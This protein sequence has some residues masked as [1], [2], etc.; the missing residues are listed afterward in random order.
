MVKDM[1][2]EKS[3][4]AITSYDLVKTFAVIIMVI[5]HIGYYFF[6][7]DLWWRAVGRLCVPV[8]MFLIGYANSRDVS[9]RLWIGA[10][11]LVGADVVVGRPVLPLNILFTIMC[12]RLVIDWFVNLM[13]KNSVNVW[14]FSIVLI[15]FI[16][17]SDFITEYGTQA[18]IIAIYGYFVR[19]KEEVGKNITSNYMMFSLLVFVCFQQ[20]VFNF[21]ALEFK[22]MFVGVLIVHLMLFCFSLR[23][24]PKLTKMLPRSLT[25]FFQF[26]GHYTLEIYV[27]HL[28]AFKL[29]AT[30]LG[31]E[32]FEWFI[33]SSGLVAKP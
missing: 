21:F 10:F 32:G 5:D 14:L 17:P 13:L 30:A 25:W 28:L 33:F 9:L 16:L 27:V 15:V 7:D 22:F 11:V 29:L 8:W 12:I 24:Y 31:F 26:C 1:V 20:I 6:P 18:L 23:T 3:F 4:V 19:H 2:K